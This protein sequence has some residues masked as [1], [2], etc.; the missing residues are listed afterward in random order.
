MHEDPLIRAVG[1]CAAALTAALAAAVGAVLVRG[2]TAVPAAWWGVAACL[3]AAGDFA[4]RATGGDGDPAERSA[5]R[6]AVVALSL[7]PIMSILGAKRPQHGVWQFI[8][9]SLA[10]VLALPAVVAAVVRPGTPPDVHLVERVFVLGLLIVGWL[11]F[12]ATRHGVAATIVAAGQLLWSREFLPLGGPAVAGSPWLDTA[13]ALL[14]A[15]GAA[16]AAI[17]SAGAAG[18]HRQLRAFDERE[19]VPPP[20][21]DRI[22]PAFDAL[23]ETLGAA[24]TLRIAERFNAVAGERGWPWR[25][26]FSGLE[27]NTE[28]LDATAERAAERTLR[29]LMLRFV[30]SAWLARHGWS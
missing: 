20:L 25:L 23:R 21:R 9:A 10:L 12:V 19:T 22:E 5:L 6:L 27:A 1:G 3:A 4:W 14:V 15:A 26:R 16:V 18:R 2:S 28:R 8:V 17:Q 30:T 7:C 11:N 13:A 29:G 24:W